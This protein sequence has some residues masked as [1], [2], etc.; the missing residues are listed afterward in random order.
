MTKHDIAE[1][2]QT[3]REYLGLSMNAFGRE[4]GYT[5]KQISRYEKE[6]ASIS[7][8]V[9]DKIVAAYGVAPE[10][11]QEAMPVADAVSARNCEK[12]KIATRITERRIECGLNQ[13]ELARLCE[14]SQTNISQIEHCKVVVTSTMARKLATVL[15]VGVDWLLKGDERKKNYPEDGKLR[16]WLWEH[17]EIRKELWERMKNG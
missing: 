17:E 14:C 11:F 13:K 6:T 4:I 1:K 10:Y 15:E 5:G 16:E 8:E 3:L 7:D 12:E 9:I 2:L